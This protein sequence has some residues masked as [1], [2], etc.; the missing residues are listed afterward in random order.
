[1]RSRPPGMKSNTCF[2]NT[3][4]SAPR[5]KTDLMEWTWL[6]KLILAHLLTDFVLQPKSWIV[7]RTTR[8]F[9]APQL[10]IHGLVT[11]L[12]AGLF[13]GFDP[14]WVAPLVLLTHTLIDGLK[15]YRPPTIGWFLADQAAHVLVLVAC[16][17]AVWNYKGSLLPDFDLLFTP[18][19]L[20]LTIAF[21][22]V[23]KPMGIFIGQFTARWRARLTMEVVP[24]KNTED[25]FA[26]KSV[27]DDSL[28]TAG[29]W[30]GMAERVII[31]I[32]VLKGQ[33]EAFGLL[34]AAKSIIRFSDSQRT[35]AK[36]EYLLIGTL[37]S[38]LLALGVGLITLY[39]LRKLA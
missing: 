24:A 12:L 27:S 18:K 38:V 2:L 28:A 13:I 1:M 8:H 6:L 22:L 20:L 29:S 11:A 17:F 14:W 15:S 19:Y 3:K 26:A 35:E 9:A 30:I 10:Y 37:T 36:T 39:L 31:L 23:T 34:I 32:L 33:Y 16:W 7:A 21:V 5:Q 4:R 25:P